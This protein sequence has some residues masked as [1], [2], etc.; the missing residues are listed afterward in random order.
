M[1][2]EGFVRIT[3]KTSRSS[4]QEPQLVNYVT[5]KRFLQWNLMR[6]SGKTVVQTET[7]YVGKLTCYFSRSKVTI[8]TLTLCLKSL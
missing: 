2:N 4:S 7:L 1:G 6:K 5:K 8:V 3:R